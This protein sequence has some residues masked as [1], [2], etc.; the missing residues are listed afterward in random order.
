MTDQH[1]YRSVVYLNYHRRPEDANLLGFA[2]QPIPQD[3]GDALYG[4]SLA[5]IG[6]DEPVFEAGAGHGNFIA[7]LKGKGFTC[8]QGAD[9]ASSLVDSARRDGHDVILGNALEILAAKP[10]GTLGAIVAID[11][12]EHLTKS[13][14]VSLLNQSMRCLRPGGTLLIQTV[15]GQGLFPGQIMYGDFSHVTI[16]NPSSLGQLLSAT[17]FCDP[18][19]KESVY[20]GYGKKAFLRRHLWRAIKSAANLCRWAEAGKRQEIWSENMICTA[21]KPG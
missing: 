12:V 15:N 21:K 6:K 20:F 13:E 4:S 14:L 7:Y 10:D 9:L 19:F 5:D 8:I 2:P 3:F 17:G 1:E 16:L 11:V 18:V